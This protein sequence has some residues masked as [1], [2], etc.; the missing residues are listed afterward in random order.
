MVILDYH[1]KYIPLKPA[2][3]TDFKYSYKIEEFHEPQNIIEE[4]RQL[5]K[6]VINNVKKT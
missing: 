6:N 4:I 3:I 2:K 1:K 5:F